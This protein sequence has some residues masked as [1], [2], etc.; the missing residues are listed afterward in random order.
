M[1]PPRLISIRSEDIADSVVRSRF[2]AYTEQHP[3]RGV[4]VAYAF[5]S[6][7]HG[8]RVGRPRRMFRLMVHLP[9]RPELHQ[10][11]WL[12]GWRNWL[13]WRALTVVCGQHP[14]LKRLWAQDARLTT[15][16]A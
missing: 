1:K 15:G 8:A 5:R 14:E 7:E 12:M 10:K 4:W 2:L 11:V 6:V 16:K 3:D 9:A 13:T